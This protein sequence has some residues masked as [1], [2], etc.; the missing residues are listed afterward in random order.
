VDYGFGRVDLESLRESRPVFESRRH[1]LDSRTQLGQAM[2]VGLGS[3]Q[4]GH[5]VTVVDQLAYD[6]R[7]DKARRTS[8][9]HLHWLPRLHGAALLTKPWSMPLRTSRPM[10]TRTIAAPR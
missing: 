4:R 8:H 5:L 9:E 3:D 2:Q 1:Q 7:A 6:V 10:L